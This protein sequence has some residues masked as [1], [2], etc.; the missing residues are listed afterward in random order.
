M[1]HAKEITL[2][3]EKKIKG[4]RGGRKEKKS[5]NPLFECTRAYIFTHDSFILLFSIHYSLF[6][7]SSEEVFR[8][9]NIR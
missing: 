8:R 3:A 7:I 5:H 6:Q 9:N 1:L 4:G 2:L